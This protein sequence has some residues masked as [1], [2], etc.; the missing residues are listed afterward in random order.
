MFEAW[1]AWM[2]VVGVT[3]ALVAFGWWAMRQQDGRPDRGGQATGRKA[4]R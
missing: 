4:E 1:D 3:L 2:D